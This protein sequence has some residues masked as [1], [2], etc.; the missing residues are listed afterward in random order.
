MVQPGLPRGTFIT[1][2]DGDWAKVKINADLEDGG[3][4]RARLQRGAGWNSSQFFA[5]AAFC[6]IA[7]ALC[8]SRQL[9]AEAGAV[10]P[11]ALHL[12][13]NG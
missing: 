4:C 1:R 5:M 6:I 3:A 7:L 13:R 12:Q 10:L 9:Q 2:Q 8:D 11:I